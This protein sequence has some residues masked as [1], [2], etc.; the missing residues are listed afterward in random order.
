ML[1]PRKRRLNM[2][3]NPASKVQVLKDKQEKLQQR[4]NIELSPQGYFF[5]HQQNVMEER[6]S[7]FL[8]NDV[9]HMTR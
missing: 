2:E 8:S 4:L 9:H 5:I 3:V 6:G 7:F 1:T